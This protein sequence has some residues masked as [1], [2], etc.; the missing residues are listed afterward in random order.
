MEVAFRYAPYEK[1][2]F[3]VLGVL[4]AP[5]YSTI[6]TPLTHTFVKPFL[7]NVHFACTTI[8]VQCPTNSWSGIS[9]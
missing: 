2:T 6:N 9:R 5:A 1:Y 8:S 7:F 4:V 3:A